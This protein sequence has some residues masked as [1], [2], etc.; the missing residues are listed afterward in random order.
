MQFASIQENM[1]HDVI[2]NIHAV[3]SGSPEA[4]VHYNARKNVVSRIHE[5]YQAIPN[6]IFKMETDSKACSKG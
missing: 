3:L 2:D 5:Y 4:E 1:G 6:K